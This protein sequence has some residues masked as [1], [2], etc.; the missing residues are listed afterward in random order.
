MKK[1][2][3]C[4]KCFLERAIDVRATFVGFFSCSNKE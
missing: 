4:G 3:I 1:S 2:G